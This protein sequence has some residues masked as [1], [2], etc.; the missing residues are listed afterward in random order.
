LAAAYFLL[1]EGHACA[2]FDRHP[3]PGGALRSQVDPQAL[4][5]AVLDAEMQQLQRLGA[6]FRPG[7]ELGCA[8][9]LESLAREFD[10]VLLALGERAKAQAPKFGLALSPAGIKVESQT[11]LTSQPKV[12]AAGSAVKPLK[13]LVRAM[14]EG[15]NVAASIHRLLS[16]Q[17]ECPGVVPQAKEM[18]SEPPYVGSYALAGQ[19]IQRLDK[20]FSSMMG[21][22]LDGELPMFMAGANPAPRVAPASGPG[23]GFNAQEACGEAGRCLHC[24]CR[25]AGNCKLQHYAGL[26]GAE[27]N[28]FREQRRRFEQLLQH[29]ELIFEPGKCILCGICVQL[30]EQAREPLGLTFI[31]R[32]F[33]VRVGAPLNHTIAEGLQKAAAQCVEHCPTGALAFKSGFD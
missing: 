28:R 15:R 17:T 10:A 8:L 14:A 26:Y 24:D 18:K 31:G 5:P 1:L 19:G 16:E 22:L 11:G 7:I 2:L 6:R 3:E 4:P 29:G 12:F 33:E 9:S 21:R 25:A 30:A 32:G 13:Q 27:P 20:Q 23:S